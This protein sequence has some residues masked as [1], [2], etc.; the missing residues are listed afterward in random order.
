MNISVDHSSP[1]TAVMTYTLNRA[2]IH[3]LDNG[4]F[5]NVLKNEARAVFLKSV[6]EIDE[7]LRNIVYCLPA[8][9]S[10]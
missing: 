8:K 6:N 1:N 2:L 4:E 9:T 10:R 3:I 5:L 7:F